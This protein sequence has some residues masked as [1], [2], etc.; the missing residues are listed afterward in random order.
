MCK[1]VSLRRT[2][3]KDTCRPPKRVIKPTHGR[4]EEGGGAKLTRC[5]N[6]QG[7]KDGSKLTRKE[8]YGNRIRGHEN[9]T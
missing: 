5:K 6:E 8:N 9:D 1:N 2:A 4:R 3:G 7:Q